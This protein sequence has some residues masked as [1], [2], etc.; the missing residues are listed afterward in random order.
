MRSRYERV[1]TELRQAT[2][3][4]RTRLHCPSATVRPDAAGGVPRQSLRVSGPI[5][6]ASRKV[7][8]FGGGVRGSGCA[9]P[10]LVPYPVRTG[11]QA[12]LDLTGLVGGGAVAVRNVITAG[13]SSRYLTRKK[14]AT[15]AMKDPTFPG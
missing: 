6:E 3:L 1:G 2:P 7:D 8:P 4:P 14:T 10:S 11:W 5:G 15:V 12:C 9:A 13:V